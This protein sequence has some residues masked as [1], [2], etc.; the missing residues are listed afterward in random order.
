MKDCYE[1]VVHPVTVDELGTEL[2]RMA[3][4]KSPDKRG[5]VAELL[6]HT[7]VFRLSSI[8]EFFIEILKPE[9]VT[10]KCWQETQL[11]VLFKKGDPT[12]PE[13]YHAR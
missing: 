1:E 4:K 8:A 12:L 6:K 2:T 7:G 13:N 9:A 11:K 5:I 3:N 10:P